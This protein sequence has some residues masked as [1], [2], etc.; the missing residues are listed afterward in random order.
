MKSRTLERLAWVL[1][2]GGLLLGCLGAFVLAAGTAPRLG[3]ALVVLGAAGVAG[4]VL[5]IWLRSRR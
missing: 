1:L 3:G 4:G 2:Y 5:S